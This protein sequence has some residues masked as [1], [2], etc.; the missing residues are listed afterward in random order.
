MNNPNYEI[1]FFEK[2]FKLSEIESYYENNIY[3]I[4]E[5]IDEI[6]NDFSLFYKNEINKI[7]K[8]IFQRIY[9]I[10]PKEHYINLS[11]ALVN[12]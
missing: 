1:K 12:L 8:D 7:S 6:Y 4:K 10:R 3:N 11:G 2:S 9:K 5:Q